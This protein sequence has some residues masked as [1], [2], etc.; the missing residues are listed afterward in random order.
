MRRSGKVRKKIHCKG[1][2]LFVKQKNNKMRAAILMKA[3]AVNQSVDLGV[4]ERRKTEDK[5]TN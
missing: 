4:E 5:E 1:S 2:I 3:R